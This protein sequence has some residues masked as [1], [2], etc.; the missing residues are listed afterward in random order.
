MT[1]PEQFAF[2]NGY[3][4]GQESV[5]QEARELREALRDRVVKPAVARDWGYCHLC[6]NNPWAEGDPE[7]HAPGCLAALPPDE[8]KG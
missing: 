4:A 5:R 2:E 8:T 7:Q 6:R 3:A 1:T